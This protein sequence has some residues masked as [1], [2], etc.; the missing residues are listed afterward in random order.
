M[1]SVTPPQNVA[2][3][4]RKNTVA[5]SKVL[6]MSSA[7]QNPFA[8]PSGMP[9]TSHKAGWPIW[10]KSLCCSVVFVGGDLCWRLAAGD[11]SL[12]NG[13]F[14][15]DVTNPRLVD[16]WVL[17]A[18]PPID[19]FMSVLLEISPSGLVMY[20]IGSC[21]VV[22]GLVSAGFMLPRALRRASSRVVDG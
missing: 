3:R 2:V 16:R 7:E 13:L 5:W 17:G 21:C 14:Y 1:E 8:A 4:S 18:T 22:W 15:M 12:S 6:I 9:V 20:F 11:I 19:P 10:L